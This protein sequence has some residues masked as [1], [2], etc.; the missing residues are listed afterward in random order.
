MARADCPQCGGSGWVVSERVG[1]PPVMRYR[2]SGASRCDCVAVA[3]PPQPL[4][5]DSEETLNTLLSIL[6]ELSTLR[7]FNE[8]FRDDDARTGLVRLVGKMA[9][10]IEQV[11]RLVDALLLHYNDWPGPAEVRVVFCALVGRPCDGIVKTWSSVFLDGVIPGTE[12]LG[13]PAPARLLPV[14]PDRLLIEGAVSDLVEGSALPV[15]KMKPARRDSIPPEE[16]ERL[17]RELDAARAD[18]D[19]SRRAEI[20]REINKLLAERKQRAG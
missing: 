15:P 18:L 6:G 10:S 2:A 12:S 7:F 17:N 14:G 13:A 5:V 3:P 1:G 19:A 4:N 20:E 11:R 8:C 16:R 9:S